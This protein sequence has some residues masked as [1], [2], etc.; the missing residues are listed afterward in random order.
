MPRAPDLATAVL[1]PDM[2]GPPPRDA[3]PDLLVDPASPKAF[4]TLQQAVDHA[5]LQGGDRR[6]TVEL[7]PGSHTGPVYIPRPGPP[8]TIRGRPGPDRARLVADIDARMPGAEYRRRYG[9][10]FRQA[11]PASRAIHERIAARTHIGTDN[12]AV[13]RVERDGTHLAHLDITNTHAC[14]RPDADGQHQA[15]ALH[16]AKADGLHAHDLR[17]TSH[18]DTLYL[19]GTGRTHLT[20]CLIE[21]D[22]DFIFGGATALFERCEIRTRIGRT[23]RTW[24]LAPSTRIDAAHGFVCHDC[25]FTA[26]GTAPG[27]H[28]VARQWFEGVRATPYAS[29]DHP[30]CEVSLGSRSDRSGIISRQT[31]ES[32]GK[33]ALVGC[34][35]GPHL[36][37]E[38]PWDNWGGSPGW[39]P[40]YRP[41]QHGPADFL[42]HL[43][44]WL[45]AQRLDYTHLDPDELWLSIEP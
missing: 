14:D 17:L 16:M 18:Q 20:D 25:D 35:L 2:A 6:L 3:P 7:A 29:A 38:R 1:G 15:V 36:N 28:F 39:S 33:V 8:L 34:R 13:L 24:A 19:Q 10:V 26:E 5:S 40:R 41:V 23:D 27:H 11:H 12:S 44:R 43:E 30:A 42:R 4:A 37:A 22:V 21:G 31:L 9:N 45:Q 32:V